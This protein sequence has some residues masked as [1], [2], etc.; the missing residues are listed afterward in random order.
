MNTFQINGKRRS[1]QRNRKYERN[2]MDILE[3]KNK[4]SDMKT[5]LY[6]FNSR[7]KLTEERQ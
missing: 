2:Q 3:L 4:M 6:G 5:A 1:Q 7:E